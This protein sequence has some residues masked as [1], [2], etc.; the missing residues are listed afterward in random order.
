MTKPTQSRELILDIL[1]EILENG[2]YSHIILRQALEKYQYLEKQDRAL[3]TRVVEGTIEYRLTIDAVID[4]CS[5]TKVERMKPIIRTILRM[6]VYQIIWMDR[7]PDSAVCNEAVKLAEKRR[8]VGL[9]GFVNG[10]LRTISRRKEEFVFPDWSRRYSMPDW[11]IELWKKQYPAETVEGML[12]AFLQD[13]PTTVRCNLDRASMEEI[14]TS[15]KSQNVD[16]AASPLSSNAL[17][18]SH[19]D[20]LESLE[21]FGNGWI[22]VQDVSSSFVGDVADPQPGD[23]VLDVCGAPGGK[24]L[25]IAD[26]LKGTGLVV[27][28]DLSEQKIRMVEDNMERTG[29]T[30]MRAEVWDALEFDPEWEGRADIVIADLP[31]SGLGIIGKK[32]DIKYQVTEE[33][34]KALAELQKE[35]L[36]VVSRYVKPGGK[37]IYST[38]TI[39]RLENEDQREWFLSRFPFESSPIDGMLGDAVRE[40]TMKDGYVQLVPGRYPCDGF[41]IAAFKRVQ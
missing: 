14:E 38:C 32:P 15:L 7:I 33:K 24:S 20:Y 30:N 29:F 41:F 6:S 11:L 19:Y 35:I 23:M 17:L 18:I 37:L 22:Q 4:A 40:D 2:G 9:K 36:S 21:A 13:M 10:V 8:F 12:K 27:V 39:D 5:K 25:H 16:V 34:L 1:M 3:I 26:R 28:R 31:C